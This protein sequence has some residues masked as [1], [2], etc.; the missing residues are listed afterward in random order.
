MSSVPY[1]RMSDPGRETERLNLFH[2]HEMV[3]PHASVS[4]MSTTATQGTDDTTPP[5]PTYVD[6]V[7]AIIKNF[8]AI[9][10]RYE[11]L[12]LPRVVEAAKITGWK[13]HEGWEF[14]VIEPTWP[15][16]L[17]FAF[18]FACHGVNIYDT[19]C[20][21]IG[22]TRPAVIAGNIDQLFSLTVFV[23]VAMT[24]GIY[25]S[26]SVLLLLVFYDIS[27][28][29]IEALAYDYPRSSCYD[30]IGVFA[31]VSI[32]L[33]D[34]PYVILFCTWLRVFRNE[35]ANMNFLAD[36]FKSEID[37]LYAV[38]PI[39][40]QTFVFVTMVCSALNSIMLFTLLYVIRDGWD[41]KKV[42]LTA[43]VILPGMLFAAVLAHWIARDGAI[44]GFIDKHKVTILESDNQRHVAALLK[45]EVEVNTTLLSH[46]LLTAN[47]L[48]FLF[49]ITGLALSVYFK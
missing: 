13:L 31:L 39:N 25:Y 36:N 9:D 17:G 38:L 49:F 10:R 46:S 42:I 35:C 4:R 2:G 28:V 24:K 41:W 23:V 8:V 29:V 34:F 33:R 18:V 11:P 6:H 43:R 22:S 5:P 47:A 21:D 37:D 14:T 32:A 1:R 44:R 20:S 48:P 3:A 40:T 16:L 12:L 7:K 26:W 30:S 27:I 19:S 15:W 45:L